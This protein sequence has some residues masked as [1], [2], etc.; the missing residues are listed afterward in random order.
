MF[1][2]VASR[3]VAPTPSRGRRAGRGRDVRPDLA[4]HPLRRLAALLP[5]D[6]ATR[7]SKVAARLKLSR[8][9]KKRLASAAAP[10]L[11]RNPRSRSPTGIGTDGAQD[12]LLLADRPADAGSDRDWPH[13]ALPIGG[14]DLIARGVAARPGSRADAA[15]IE[16]AM[17]SRRLPPGRPL[18]AISTK[19]RRP[20]LLASASSASLGSPRFRWQST[21]L[22][23]ASHRPAH[24]CR[25]RRRAPG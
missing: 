14:G 17:G 15:R 9:R 8:K 7:A 10:D 2:P 23:P 11:G 16:D 25:P 13:P 12:R 1:A 24:P 18:D 5:P 21:R 20:K 6:P 19:T 22:A 3:S 4:P